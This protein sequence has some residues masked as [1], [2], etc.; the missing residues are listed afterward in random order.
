[1][2]TEKWQRNAIFQAVKAGGLE[3]SECTFVYGDDGARITHLSSQSS[4]VLSGDPGRYVSTAVVGESP[5][6]ESESFTWVKVDEQVRRW[7]EEVKRDVDTPDLWA[8]LERGS[9]VLTGARY[10]DVENT[11][12]TLNEQAQIAEQ[13]QQMQEFV[14][15]TYAL[16]E[17]QMLSL[18][19]KFD[20]VGAA[21]GR[22]G[23]KDWLLLFYGVMFTVIVAGLLPP[24]AVQHIL[25][26]V[27]Q[28]LAHLFGSRG[29]PP[30]LASPS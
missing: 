29:G 8:E 11:L 3:P 23:R 17:A 2:R 9:E 5:V 26:T 16:S 19:A 24:E 27:L 6:R 15:T 22:I 30:L 7:A 28:A 18:E 14:K 20:D 25:V 1:M 10:V 21:A 13:L 4:F 12:F